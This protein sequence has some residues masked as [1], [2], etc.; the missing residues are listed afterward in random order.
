M[1]AVD[2]QNTSNMYGTWVAIRLMTK[3]QAAIKTVSKN[4]TFFKKYLS[5]V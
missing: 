5:N 4:N 1:Y 3:S 2:K